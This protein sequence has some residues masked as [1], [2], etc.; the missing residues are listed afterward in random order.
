MGSHQVT[1]TAEDI[2]DASSS[3]SFVWTIMEA[4]TPAGSGQ[5]DTPQAAPEDFSI[6]APLAET[7]VQNVLRDLPHRLAP[8]LRLTL[9]NGL[10]RLAQLRTRTPQQTQ[11]TSRHNIQARFA[12]STANQIAHAGVTRLANAGA[13]AALDAILPDSVAIWSQGEIAIGSLKANT[14]RKLNVKLANLALGID[15]RVTP[16]LTLGA[17]V[18]TS[19]DKGGTALFDNTL[20]LA[21]VLGYASYVSERNRF[22][23]RAAQAAAAKSI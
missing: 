22:A 1:V 3:E 17:Y 11:N 15:R 8:S 10:T 6:R 2:L 18:Q 9:N 4:P 5:P 13:E 16:Q 23:Q 12:D 7:S 21:N 20:S 14:G 19:N